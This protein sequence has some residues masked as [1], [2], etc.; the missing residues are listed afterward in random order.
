MVTQSP[1]K[2]K[3][4]KPS[5]VKSFETINAKTLSKLSKKANNTPNFMQGHLV[6]QCFGNGCLRE[7]RVVLSVIGPLAHWS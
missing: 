5:S 6:N 4:S 3:D 2:S 7:Y 1:P